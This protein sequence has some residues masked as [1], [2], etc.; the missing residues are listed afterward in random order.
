MAKKDEPKKRGPT[1]GATYRAAQTGLILLEPAVAQAAAGQ[2]APMAYLEAYRAQA[3]PFI[4]GVGVHA[5]DQVAGQRILGHNSALG[6]GS[7]TA[8]AAEAVPLSAGVATRD[9]AQGAAAYAAIKTG[10]DRQGFLLYEGVKI[11]GG[12]VRKASN[13]SFLRPV[14][15]PVKK[16]LASAGGAL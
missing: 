5:V 16:A 14:L 8:W 13:M 4:V 15:E 3:R 1:F 6:R 11:G 7:V 9:A 12:I 10:R 2:R